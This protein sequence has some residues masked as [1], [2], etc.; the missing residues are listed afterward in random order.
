MLKGQITPSKKQD[1]SEL[2]MVFENQDMFLYL[3]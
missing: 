1:I 2:Q 3:S